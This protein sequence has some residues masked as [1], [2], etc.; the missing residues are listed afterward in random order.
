MGFGFVDWTLED[1]EKH[2]TRIRNEKAFNLNFKNNASNLS[3][4]SKKSKYG[5]KKCEYDGIAFD[6]QKERDRYIELLIL[7]CQKK[8]QTCNDKYRLYCK[9]NL[10]LMVKK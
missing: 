3:Y 2:N 5:A 6:S 7:E 8:Y 4:N 1:V 9:M 10:K